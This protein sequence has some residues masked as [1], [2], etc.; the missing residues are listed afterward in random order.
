[1]IDF[2]LSWL[3][4]AGQISAMFTYE[5]YCGSNSNG[6]LRNA[7]LHP[8]QSCPCPFPLDQL[9]SLANTAKGWSFLIF[10]SRV[11]PAWAGEMGQSCSSNI[12][13]RTDSFLKTFFTRSLF[14]PPTVL[15]DSRFNGKCWNAN[16]GHKTSTFLQLTSMNEE[17]L[18]NLEF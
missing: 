9:S 18:K 17:T 15:L 1:M 10:L 7:L 16:I 6:A 12:M 4:S 5:N 11:S 13:P 8:G 14:Q 3:K 2:T